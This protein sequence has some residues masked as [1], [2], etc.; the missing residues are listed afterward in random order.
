MKLLNRCVASCILG[1]TLYAGQAAAAEHTLRIAT[2]APKASSWGKVYTAWQK[3]LEKQSEGKLELQIYFTGVPGNEDAMVSK[4]KTGQLD[5]AAISAVG[6]SLVYKSVL[7]LQ[8][9]GVLT[10]WAQLDQVRAKIQPEL[11][12]GIR[13]AGFDIVGWG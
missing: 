12:A 11:D 1:L 4:I 7:V 6:L 8:L 10:S 3:A 9:P 13:A 5:G 2:I